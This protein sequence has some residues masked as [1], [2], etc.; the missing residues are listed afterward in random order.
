M[1]FVQQL[2]CDQIEEPSILWNFPLLL[3]SAFLKQS[4]QQL[5]LADDLLGEFANRHLARNDD[6]DDDDCKNKWEPSLPTIEEEENLTN[7]HNDTRVLEASSSTNSNN[8]S[9]ATNEAQTSTAGA[10]AAM[11]QAALYNAG[12]YLPSKQKRVLLGIFVS[13]C[14]PFVPIW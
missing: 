2:E 12:A 6:D 10:A 11:W 5:L 3:L 9:K 14:S 7:I 1:A 13:C 4:D 8:N